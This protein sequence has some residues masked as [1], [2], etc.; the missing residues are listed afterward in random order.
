MVTNTRQGAQALSAARYMQMQLTVKDTHLGAPVSCCR[1]MCI[2]WKYFIDHRVCLCGMDMVY[3]AIF[4]V[5]FHTSDTFSLTP[6][7]EIV[8]GDV[9]EI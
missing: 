5:N 8:P 6:V 1:R 4:W 2:A 9:A 7:I 3:Q